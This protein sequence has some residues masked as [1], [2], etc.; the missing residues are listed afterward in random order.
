MSPALFVVGGLVNSPPFIEAFSVRLNRFLLRCLFRKLQN[1][2]NACKFFVSIGIN[3][4]AAWA[5]ETL[6]MLRPA[7]AIADA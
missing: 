4:I 7:C 2:E 3:F 1:W 6:Q 5:C